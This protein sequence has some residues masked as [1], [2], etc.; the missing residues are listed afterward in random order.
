MKTPGSHKQM[1]SNFTNLQKNSCTH[2]LEQLQT[3]SC[4][5]TRQE[6]RQNDRGQ[7]DRQTGDGH[8]DRQTNG[9]TD[10][11]T[12]GQ[13]DR[14]TRLNQ[15]IPPNFAQTLFFYAGK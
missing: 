8:T 4:P 13:T 7:T 11:Q 2:L 6:D 9:R 10:R 12:Y 1:V 3:K 15:F 5:Q 14:P